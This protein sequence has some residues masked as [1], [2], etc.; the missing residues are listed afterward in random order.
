MSN[1]KTKL[2]SFGV[3]GLIGIP[4]FTLMLFLVV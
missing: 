2:V 4:V 1:T 3:G